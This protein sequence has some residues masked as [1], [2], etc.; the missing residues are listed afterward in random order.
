MSFQG[1]QGNEQ[2]TWRQW[3]QLP[4]LPPW[5]IRPSH[6]QRP[7]VSLG[8]SQHIH[9]ITNLWKFRLNWSS[10]LQEIIERKK[11]SCCT[12]L[13]A[14]ICLREM[15]ETQSLSQIQNFEWEIMS[16]SKTMLLQRESF[17]TMFYTINSSPM[18][19][20]KSVFKLNF[21]WSNYQ[22]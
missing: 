16:F 6:C 5:S 10:K 14:F 9:K 17:P 15:L 11:H 13:R 2:W 1:H 18:L 12:N 22:T 4:S 20:T 21:F 7:V 8:V 3:R 19:V